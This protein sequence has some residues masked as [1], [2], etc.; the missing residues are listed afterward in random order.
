MS[1]PES[2]PHSR[3]EHEIRHYLELIAAH[4]DRIERQQTK[5]GKGIADL[6]AVLGNVSDALTKLGADLRDVFTFIKTHPNIDLTE[7]VAKGQAIAD[8]LAAVD[9]EALKEEEP[10]PVPPTP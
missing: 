1:S 2:H 6:D 7:Q 4:L 10:V 8:A 3:L 9:L 5:M